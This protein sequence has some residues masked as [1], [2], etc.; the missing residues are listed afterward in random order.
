M[1][2]ITKSLEHMAW[3]N[4]QIFAELS[5]LPEDVYG[6]RAAEGEWPLGRIATH[7]LGSGEWYR[8]ILTGRKW[9]EITAIRTHEI[10]KESALYLAALD[11]VLID[12]SKL[13]DEIIQ[14]QNENGEDKT[15]RSL[16]LAQA[17]MHS[18]E[19]KGQLATILKMHGYF[20][21]LDRFDV[22]SFEST[23]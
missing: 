15:T 14:F 6:L 12:Q 17:V 7:L 16:I 8:Y 1:I 23:H 4:Q 19:H 20:L 9:T 21:D 2:S 3:S 13:A 10:L 22:W 5:K 11:Q 18:A